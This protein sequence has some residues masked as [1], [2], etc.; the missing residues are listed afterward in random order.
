[1]M[2][3][4]RILAVLA[5]LG[6]S[7]VAGQTPTDFPSNF[8]DYVNSLRTCNIQITPTSPGQFAPGELVLNKILTTER[9][10]LYSLIGSVAGLNYHPGDSALFVA[11][12]YG[13][14]TQ[15]A[16]QTVIYRGSAIAN[17][18]PGTTINIYLYPTETL[19]SGIQTTPIILGLTDSLVPGTLPTAVAFDLD[20]LAANSEQQYCALQQGQNASI[21]INSIPFANVFDWIAQV[22]VSSNQVVDCTNEPTALIYQWAFVSANYGDGAQETISNVA[23]VFTFPTSPLTRVT[24]TEGTPN[25]NVSRAMTF[26]VSI[27]ISTTFS[28]ALTYI[29]LSIG[30]NGAFSTEVTPVFN[31]WIQNVTLF[32]NSFL[33]GRNG[34]TDIFVAVNGAMTVLYGD[35]T[36][37][38]DSFT[39]S[40]SIPSA[41]STQPA[42]CAS[43][44]LIDSSTQYN[45]T[46]NADVQVNLGALNSFMQN[47]MTDGE[48]VFCE[49][50]TTVSQTH[51]DSVSGTCP[52]SYF[53]S[54]VT[55][56]RNFTETAING[57]VVSESLPPSGT[58]F[59]SNP[60]FFAAEVMFRGGNDT[61]GV[62]LQDGLCGQIV[63]NPS[64][65]NFNSG[66]PAEYFFT[67]AILLDS[68]LCPA[69]TAYSGPQSC[70]PVSSC[71]GP[72]ISTTCVITGT[73]TNALNVVNPYYELNGPCYFLDQ[74]QNCY[75]S[76]GTYYMIN[77]TSMLNSAV[78]CDGTTLS[79][80]D[81]LSVT[82]TTTAVR[83]GNVLPQFAQIETF[84]SSDSV[85]NL[86]NVINNTPNK[87]TVP[88][89]ARRDMKPKK[90][91]TVTPAIDVTP[92]K[93]EKVVARRSG[94]QS[95]PV[96]TV[97][98]TLTLINNQ[99]ILVG[100]SNADLAA[101]NATG[102]NQTEIAL[103]LSGLCPTCSSVFIAE[104]S[105]TISLIISVT[106][107]FPTD[108]PTATATPTSGGTQITIGGGGV[109][110]G[111]QETIGIVFATP[112]ATPT[113]SG[114]IQ[115]DTPPPVPVLRTDLI[116]TFASIAGAFV[117]ATLLVV[118]FFVFVRTRNRK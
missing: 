11:A 77:S 86:C 109:G 97:A 35:A 33:D 21:S 15:G 47:S 14:Y 51:C 53:V 42:A 79:Q 10:G 93:V 80:S 19:F 54:R 114:S 83:F 27:S 45:P 70:T 82:C 58:P 91:A 90:A 101:F 66:K 31:P 56:E 52:K 64:L 48:V 100:F 39:Y 110:V 38:Q 18:Y 72:S 111:P 3:V 88:H 5:L 20:I 102:G 23:A 29:P 84:V 63:T 30:A 9:N 112:T 92:G 49:I 59:L 96:T 2:L 24:F 94:S 25:W 8:V 46:D 74:N 107:E 16:N 50:V 95:A 87:R 73:T 61:N 76:W 81:P 40:V 67:P 37:Q 34:V 68:T 98:I 108:V 60:L 105:T 104:Q 71:F 12:C 44:L 43:I 85:T 57:V 106:T 41:S 103:I 75:D 118:I 62:M 99:G 22:G 7:L 6:C 115:V 32:P 78:I 1:M 65:S 36:F 28:T 13:N 89:H 113:P 116:I 26:T 69:Y 55:I 4:A 117:L 17:L